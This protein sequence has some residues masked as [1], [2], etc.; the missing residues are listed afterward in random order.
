[1]S[2]SPVAV[3]GPVT[4]Y[5]S[6]ASTSRP[7]STTALVS[8]SMNSGTPSVR[9]VIW[10]AISL[11]KAL[12]PVTCTIISARSRRGRRLRLISV[13]CGRPTQGGTNSGRKVTIA[14]SGRLERPADDQLEKFERGGIGP[15]RVL[16]HQQHR[17]T[18][19]QP[20]DLRHQRP[21]CLLLALLRGEV[22]RG[23]AVAG[24]NRQQIR[25]QGHGLAEIIGPPG[26]A[27]PRAWSAVAPSCPRAG[28]RPPVRAA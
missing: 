6:P 10:S 28:T 23:I 21:Q 22:E 15:M 2:G 13:T 8:S 20:L 5:R 19:R 27:P 17:L 11:G 14:R 3:T 7:L 12:P 9:S 18:R 26:R 4:I 25:Q 24:R 1:M 16:D